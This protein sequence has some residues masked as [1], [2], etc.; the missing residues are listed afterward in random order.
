MKKLTGFIRGCHHTG[1]LV[2]VLK[3][4]AIPLFGLVSL[5]WVLLRV[6]PK[7]QRAAYPCMKVAIP[8]ASS[9]LIYLSG[10]AISVVVFKKAVRKL[11][12][13]KYLLAGM[14]LL[15][16][17]G[18][19][20]VAII[21]NQKELFAS[22]NESYD[23]LDPLGPN[24]P[25]GE[26]K[27]IIPGRVVW[28]HNPDATNENCKSEVYGDGYFLDKN[29]SQ[30][31]VDEMVRTAILEVS[32]AANESEAWTSVFTYFNSTHGRGENGYSAGEKIYFK[33]NAVHAWSTNKD[34][35]IRNDDS[36]GNVDTSPQ[37]ILAVLR[38][39]INKAGVPEEAI[40]IGDPYT[41]VFKH[42]YDKL[43][44]EFPNVHYLSKGD[45][46]NREK[47]RMTNTDTL[48][49]SDRGSIL[50]LDYDTFFD[51]AVHADYVINVPAIKGHR[52]GG[53]TFFAKNHF[54][55]NTRDGAWRLHKGLH[56]EDYD[57]PLRDQ[58]RQYRVMVDN[59]SY[60]HLGG[61]TLIYIG[62]LLWGTSYEH[63]PPAKFR[64]APFNNDWSSS[65]LVSLD[66]VAVASV[67]L[68]ILQE[69]FKVEDLTT[70][71]PRYTYVR[72]GAVD[73]YL[74]QAASSEWW[75]E[76]I[77][78]D[79]EMDGTPIVS[80]GVHEHW[81][82]AVNRQY[83][84]NLGSGEGI[85]LIYKLTQ[86]D[87]TSVLEKSLQDADFHAWLSPQNSILNLEFSREIQDAVVVR[88]FNSSGQVV[89]TG[90]LESVMAHSPNQLALERHEPGYYVV[91]VQS[92][93]LQMSRALLIN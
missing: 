30:E 69:E 31:L 80:L 38:Q 89:Q 11:S 65:I 58:Y 13:S 83:S 53:V 44:A 63:D 84:R 77:V 90:R 16:G 32:G 64:S 17:L 5:I 45:Y 2:K 87:H 21:G 60:E 59:M 6:L 7:P 50:D 61:K 19:G 25:I 74:H 34:L 92:G 39:L 81:N 3:K 88:I 86:Q 4:W 73:D 35:S 36:Y 24:V 54:G 41:Q 43:H 91:T 56:R 10:L 71:P 55:S 79:P 14:L 27:G 42:I 49:Y 22:E 66:P 29:C 1:H 37:V 46:D 28:V 67:A 85:E 70:T 8:F 51:C 15:A 75:P 9:L 48:Y 93:T 47:L 57:L 68:D 52:W 18:F 12:E 62:D 82:D 72:F 23:Y 20:M 76:G 40:Y 78:Y 33:I 26:A